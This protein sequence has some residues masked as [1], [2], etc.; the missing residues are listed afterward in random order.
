MQYSRYFP[1]CYDEEV[2][3]GPLGNS[4]DR[5]YGVL[6]SSYAY[7]LAP[8]LTLEDS[9][10]FSIQEMYQRFGDTI[11]TIQ[12]ILGKNIYFRACAFSTIG[13]KTSINFEVSV[14]CVKSYNK[15]AN[16]VDLDTCLVVHYN[17]DSFFALTK[18][19]R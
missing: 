16:S 13:G 19:R 2:C 5:L 1:N 14:A 11:T 3:L 6:V 4:N 15:P 8:P 17:L 12:D 9:C 7:C 10:V 18:D